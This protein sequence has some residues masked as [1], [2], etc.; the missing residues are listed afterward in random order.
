MITRG[1]AR[2]Q[3]QAQ[4][5]GQMKRDF[6]QAVN[7]GEDYLVRDRARNEGGAGA[8]PGGF[9]GAPNPGSTLNVVPGA[10]RALSPEV[11]GAWH[12]SRS[13]PQKHRWA[14]RGSRGSGRGAA[15]TDRPGEGQ[16]PTLGLTV[17]P[18]PAPKPGHTTAN[19]NKRPM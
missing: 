14:D 10:G 12:R 2:S 8:L 6:S 19:S 9:S 3:T 1:L 4:R 15:E 11:A 7:K 17:Q 18:L 16:T 5:K 13:E